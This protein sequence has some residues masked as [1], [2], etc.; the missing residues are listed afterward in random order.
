MA[1]GPKRNIS[2]SYKVSFNL[3]IGLRIYGKNW[4]KIEQLVKT[5]S[6]SQIRSHAQK[7]FLK[8]KLS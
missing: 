1:D 7:F 6:G 4:K 2:T 8:N 5:R 3:F